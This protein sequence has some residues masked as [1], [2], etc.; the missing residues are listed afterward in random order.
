M[1]N[2]QRRLTSLAKLYLWATHRLY[3]EFAWAYDLVS[4]VISLGHWSRCRRMA[5]DHATGGRVLEIG[6]GTGELLIEMAE[7][8]WRACGLEPSPA[9]HRVAAGKMRRR[10]VQVPRV[11]GYAQAMPFI[12]GSFDA[13]VATFPADYILSPASLQEVARLLRPPDRSTNARGGRFIIAGLFFE[14]DSLILRHASRLICGGLADNVAI[15]YDQL[16]TPAGFKLT[17]VTDKAKR[18]RCPILILEKSDVPLSARPDASDAER[19]ERLTALRLG[20]AT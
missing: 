8:H 18:F 2:R 20:E 3:N 19:C 10:G 14:T 6:F 9:M 4:W 16:A 13:I 7:R 11:R 12:D 5:L 17:M 1:G 15:R